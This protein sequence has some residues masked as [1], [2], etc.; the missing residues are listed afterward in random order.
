MYKKGQIIKIY[1]DWYNKKGLIGEAILIEKVRDGLS[2]I[3]SEENEDG[4]SYNTHN[5]PVH[6]YERWIV[7][8]KS[9]PDRF[10]NIV[11]Q[12]AQVN[13]YYLEGIGLKTLKKNVL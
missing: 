13:L 5:Q 3:Q 11:G 2:F 9:S 12:R 4:V 10:S 7:E 6:N 1:S 8:Y